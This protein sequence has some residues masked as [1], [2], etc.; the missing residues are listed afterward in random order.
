MQVSSNI[1]SDF[2]RITKYPLNQYLDQYITFI[3]RGREDI[4]NYYSGSVDKPN[5]DS[6][7]QL[8]NLLKQSEQIDQATT[9]HRNQLNNASYW[10]LIDL[11]GEVKTSLQTTYNSSKWMRSVISKNN[12]SPK[13]EVDHVLKQSQTIENVA[14]QSG[15]IDYQNDW[16][17]IA[18]RNDLKEE[19]YS[20]QGGNNLLIAFENSQSI[21]INSV[22][23]NIVGQK[24]YGKD[25]DRKLTFIDNDL[26][27]LTYEETIKQSVNI[28]AR[29][30]QQQTPEFVEDGIESS[31]VVG[32]N[33]SNIAYPILY[34]QLYSTFRKD[35]TLKSLSITNISS[36]KQA[37][38][39][40]FSVETRLG[41]QLTQ[42]TQL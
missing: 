31:I 29:L 35:D 3:E 36:E 26:K 30:R 5:K 6:F 34:R 40:E 21:F 10:E 18:L 9:N 42:T 12:F 20:L 37:L 19:Q 28:L 41:E 38:I 13:V 8:E 23:D 25:I 24:I 11:L 2:T 16:T 39:I 1:I 15:Y 17:K 22:V 33:R 27:A 4:L 7:N 32:S 14:S